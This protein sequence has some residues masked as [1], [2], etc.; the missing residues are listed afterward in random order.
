ME[1]LQFDK[2]KLPFSKYLQAPDGL[3]TTMHEMLNYAKCLLNKGIYKEKQIIKPDSLE[4]LWTP[5][6]KS[7]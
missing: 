2:P 1:K 4:L 5:R 6:I 3:Y 7:L